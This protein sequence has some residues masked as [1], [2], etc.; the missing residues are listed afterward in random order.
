MR[1]R[2]TICIAILS[3]VLA[4]APAGAADDDARALVQRVV[5]SLPDVPFVAKMKLTTP[6]K[7]EREVT[8][9]SKT[10]NDTL[11]GRYMEVTAPFDVKDV[12]YL[13]YE[14]SKGVDEQ[15]TYMPLLRRVIRLSEKTRREPFLGSTFY[16]NDMIAPSV[17]DF[18]YRFVG[19]EEIGQRR[20]RLVESLPR[21]A[22]RELYGKTIF[23]IDPDDL[24]IMRTQLFDQELK[25]AKVLIT[26]RI[27]KVDGFWT[28]LVQRMEDQRDGTDSLLETVEITYR[29]PIGDDIFDLAYIGR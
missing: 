9:Y 6:G 19:E 15:F 18:V 25:P 17:D 13:F 28:P 27:E 3:C 12:R 10:L 23:A 11:D 2:A 24:V 26:E 4:T 29:A 16:V 21:D 22:G 14:R 20:C 7:L 1:K 8:S 5:D